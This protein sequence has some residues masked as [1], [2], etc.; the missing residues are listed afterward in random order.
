MTR[1][2]LLSATA[3]CLVFAAGACATRG[4]LGGGDSDTLMKEEIA[5]IDASTMHEV[6]R[7][8][9]PLWLRT[10]ARQ[11]TGGVQMSPVIVYRDN[12]RLGGVDEL[13]DV[14]PEMAEWVSYLDSSEASATL[15]GLGSTLVEGAI[16][17]HTTPPESGP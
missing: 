2:I 3:L 12:V 8:L 11:F 5:S 10:R 7:R 15:P 6:V 17:I 13:R 4:G 14:S 9:R 16:V 1:R